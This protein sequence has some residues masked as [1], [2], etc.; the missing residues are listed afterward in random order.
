MERALYICHVDS[1]T[2][3]N[4]IAFFGPF[5]D[6]EIEDRLNDAFADLL[7]GAGDVSC[8]ELTQIEAQDLVSNTREYWMEQLQ[9][10]A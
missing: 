7:S 3:E 9:R 6:D 4:G 2:P 8:V 10:A 5:G 1:Q